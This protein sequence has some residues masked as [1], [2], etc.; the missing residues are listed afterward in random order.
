MLIYNSQMH[1]K[2]EFKPIE[3]GKVRMYVCGPTVYDQIHIGNARTFL[4]FDVI[5]RY[6]T[7]KGYA[8]TFAQNLT[9][10]DDKIINRA[11]EQG[12]TAA[13]VAEECSQAF[14]EQM[15][16]FGILDPD[17]RP[18]A[19][20]RDRCD[21]G[22]DPGLDRPGLC[23]RRAFGRRLLQRPFRHELRHRL[24][25]ECRRAHE[26]RPHRGERA[27]EGSPRLR[28][29]EGSEAGRAEL[30]EPLGQW[31]SWLAHRVRRYDPPLS[32]RPHRYP[33]RRLRPHL[34]AP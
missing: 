2:Q 12:R 13:E 15:H 29:L 22:D 5:R 26:R 19:T 16:R 6:L 31:P 7:Y 25:Q 20:R 33:R 23:L 1:K 3:P 17:I 27:E 21:A 9:D 8:V 32:R 30:A 10:V 28:A 4:C 14:I 34:P 24:R 18:R 11:N